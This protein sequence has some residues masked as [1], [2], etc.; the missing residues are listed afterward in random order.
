[1][2]VILAVFLSVGWAVVW[3]V[4]GA[5]RGIVLVWLLRQ[6]ALSPEEQSQFQMALSLYEPRRAGFI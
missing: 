6:P 3:A 4:G 2:T 5:I 1:M